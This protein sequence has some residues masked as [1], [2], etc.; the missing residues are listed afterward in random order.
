MQNQARGVLWWLKVQ[1]TVIAGE[2]IE[3]IIF[4]VRAVFGFKVVPSN[5]GLKGY[6]VH[7][8]P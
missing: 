3:G 6:W 8:L 7:I 5:F 4:M 2:V 1:K